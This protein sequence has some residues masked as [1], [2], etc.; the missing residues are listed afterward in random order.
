MSRCLAEDGPLAPTED[1][2]CPEVARMEARAAER[3][4]CL[5]EQWHTSSSCAVFV[6][7]FILYS[8]QSIICDF[9]IIIVCLFYGNVCGNIFVLAHQPFVHAGNV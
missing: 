7:S 6:Q 9:H 4:R 1:P 8:V 2:T 5:L 3:L